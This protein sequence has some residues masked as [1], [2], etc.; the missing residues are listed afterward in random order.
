[1]IR[2]RGNGQGTVT[3]SSKGMHPVGYETPSMHLWLRTHLICGKALNFALLKCG[4]NASLGADVDY[5]RI[6]VAKVKAQKKVVC[7][8]LCLATFESVRK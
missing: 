8:S 6:R 1:M 2:T 5:S 7:W 3:G 4:D